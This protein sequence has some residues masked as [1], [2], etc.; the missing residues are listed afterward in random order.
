MP[1]RKK[2][3][4][5]R[6]G[7]PEDDRVPSDTYCSVTQKEGWFTEETAAKALGAAQRRQQGR[8]GKL[9]RRYYLCPWGQHFHLTSR[10][11]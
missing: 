7:L 11:T 5:S 9:E 8:G 6:K 3:G 2:K 1:G 10:P 4:R